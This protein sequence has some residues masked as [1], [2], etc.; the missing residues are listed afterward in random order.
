[1]PQAICYRDACAREAAGGEAD[2]HVGKVGAVT[3]YHRK[4]A[5][6]LLS[7]AVRDAKVEACSPGIAK[8]VTARRCVYG[9]E[10]RDAL[11][12]L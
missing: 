5:S 9:H 2:Q 11:I 4:H 12:Q 6:R 10:I 7:G 8:P 1:L 3:G